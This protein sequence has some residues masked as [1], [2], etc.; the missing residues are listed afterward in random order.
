MGNYAAVLFVLGLTDRLKMLAE[1]AEDYVG[2]ML[3]E[4][5]LP[6]RIH[7]AKRYE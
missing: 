2:L 6:K 1:P 5:H 7:T 3:E 4:K